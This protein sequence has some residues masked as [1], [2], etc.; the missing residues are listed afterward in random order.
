M[1]E[2]ARQTWFSGG[3]RSYWF[4]YLLRTKFQIKF[5]HILGEML[6]LT[7][8]TLAP[9]LSD[10][11][12]K[13]LWTSRKSLKTS[14]QILVNIWS[15]PGR[16]SPDWRISTWLQNSP[17]E[18]SSGTDTTT[19]KC[20]DISAMSFFSVNLWASCSD[21]SVNSNYQWLTSRLNRNI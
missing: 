11:S 13:K 18:C 21:C 15:L 19:V 12:F 9:R 20:S 17:V 8:G 4:I 5:W 6:D 14:F 16:E 3:G 7:R 1:A 10:T 2:W